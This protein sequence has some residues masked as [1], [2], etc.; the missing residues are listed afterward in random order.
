MIPRIVP[1][2]AFQAV[3]F[4]VNNRCVRPCE[5]FLQEVRRSALFPIWRELIAC[6]TF[7][8]VFAVSGFSQPMETLVEPDVILVQYEPGAYLGKAAYPSILQIES[9]EAAFPFLEKLTGNRAQ[10]ASVQALKRVF[11]VRYGAD[12]SPYQA[13]AMIAN[14][15]EV[16]YAEPQYRGFIDSVPMPVN[17]DPSGMYSPLI[18]NDPMFAD[19]GYMQF[20]EITKAWDVVKGEEGEVV[21]AI[22]DSGVAWDHPDLAE[23]LWD[24][25][26]EVPDNRIDD[27]NN[28]F[29]DDVHGWNVYSNSGDARPL[30]QGPDSHGTEVAG[31]AVAVANNGLGLAGTSWNAKFMAV[32]VVCGPNSE[33][34]CEMG[35]GVLYAAMNG[36]HIINASYGYHTEEYSLTLEAVY[37]AAEDLGS[38]VVAAAGNDEVKLGG[39]RGHYPGSF[40]TTL[41]VCGTFGDSYNNIYN[42]GYGVDV[43]AAGNQVVSTTLNHGYGSYSG[44]SF[45]APLTSG[46]AALV[47]TRFPEFT[48]PQVREQIRATADHGIYDSNQHLPGLLGRG[49]VNAYRAVTETDK[50]SIRLVE[51]E[52]KDENED[53]GLAISEQIHITATFESFLADAENL[54][55]DWIAR[56][57]HTIFP[58]GN[59]LSLGSLQHGEK[60]TVGFSVVPSES[61]PYRSF[62][63]LEPYIKT[64]EGE[65]VS[66]GDAIGLIVNSAQLALH[67]TNTFR[68]TMTSEGNIG[69]VDFMRKEYPSASVP[70]GEITV[71]E[72]LF[73]YQAGLLIG[74]ASRVAGSV[75][76]DAS[77]EIGWIQNQDFVPAGPLM[78][79]EEEN[80]DQVSRVTM[81]DKSGSIYGGLDIIQESL[82]SSQE[83]FEDIALFRYRV[84][85]P[86][87]WTM[88]DMHVGLYFSIPVSSGVGMATYQNGNMEEVFP[89]MHM[90][91]IGG[92]YVGFAVLSDHAPKHYR[93][94]DDQW[95]DGRRQVRLPS[96]AWPGLSGGIVPGMESDGGDGQLFASGPHTVEAFSE[97]VID[98]AMIYGDDLDDLVENARLMRQLR[99]S[100]AVPVA[101]TAPKTVSIAEGGTTTFEIALAAEPPGDVTVSI[102]GHEG[103]DLADVPPSPLNLTFTPK[104]YSTVQS[105]TLTASE[106]ADIIDDEVILTLA[107]TSGSGYAT[108]HV[109][110]VTIK[111]NLILNTSE[112]ELPQEVTLWGN[113]PNPLSDATSIEF[114]LPESAQISVMVTDIL[115]RVVKMLPYGRLGAGRG[116]TIEV[117]T[118]ELTSGLYF[119]TLRV[120][121]GGKIVE[122]SNSMIIVR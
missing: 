63:F 114:D 85:N 74:A 115:G 41:S 7:A 9:V 69:Y 26:G 16:K 90:G 64:S 119:Y 81:N 46:V 65:L 48:P 11:R 40:L 44:T 82:V 102:R 13:A 67:E 77:E 111:D 84:H 121:M 62:V 56:P 14:N 83:Q 4:R 95:S 10:L 21:I 71:K 70:T 106:D 5:E 20:L 12:I 60:G 30:R 24:N 45:A 51:W 29:I 73:V 57:D 58:N 110:A 104:N 78:S 25:L 108:A 66:G 68:Y 103:T 86:I 36:A 33:F 61:A 1:V 15:P 112:S 3:I 18:P 19:E 22:V 23:N 92:G 38:L 93:T 32:N 120:D 43:C 8:G 122:R 35:K 116:H 50:V 53:G 107:T 2:L 72:E 118:A 109:I 98:F 87:N 76:S 96:E 117:N 54:T 17:H 37:Q 88:K 75:F 52:A 94:Y 39:F 89:Y 42:Y 28:G 91:R 31:A 80:G 47:K 59:R 99:D 79:F 27:D 101:L 100:W 97:V 55:L 105:V 6:L 49:Y 34:F 113:Y